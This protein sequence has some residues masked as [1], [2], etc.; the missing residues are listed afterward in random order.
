MTGKLIL[1]D[2]TIFTGEAFGSQGERAGL[3]ITYS[4]ATGY[5]EM[6]TSPPYLGRLVAFESPMIGNR[7]ATAEGF[8]SDR[9]CAEGI[10]VK[11]LSAASGGIRASKSFDE[12]SR[13]RELLGVQGVDTRALAAHI[14]DN[15]EQW[16]LLTT[17]D[18][19][20][21]GYLKRLEGIKGRIGGNPDNYR[22]SGEALLASWRPSRDNRTVV[23]LD[24]GAGK[25]FYML[26]KKNNYF[27]R[28]FGP[29]MGAKEIMGIK[30]AAVIVTNGPFAPESLKGTIQTV[31]E[32]V[33]S[34]PVF[35]IGLGCVVLGAALGASPVR[36]KCGHHGSNFSVVNLETG[37]CAVT[38]QRHSFCLS[39]KSLAKAGVKMLCRNLDDG[40]PE[41]IILKKKNAA[42]IMYAPSGLET[43]ESL[44]SK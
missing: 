32:L 11:E 37:R 12:F 16:G 33:G 24:L 2:G 21:K 13:E 40:T 22:V 38:S 30:P 28:S 44:I 14:S 25:S 29:R 35:G 18:S 31:R 17:K 9:V 34:V 6:V 19:D 27:W 4:G 3:V 8:E 26:L 42:G 23:A 39:E 10:I 7:G 43:L 20:K 5:Q 15:G 41:G 1:E 36:M